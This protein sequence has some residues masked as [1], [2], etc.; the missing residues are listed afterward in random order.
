MERLFTRREPYIGRTAADI[1]AVFFDHELILSLGGESD[2]GSAEE[3]GEGRRQHRPPHPGA[4]GQGGYFGLQ[5][6]M[7]A[8]VSQ[9]DAR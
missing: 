3:G 6:Y 5:E 7:T 1:R 9:C 2:G 4:G 8:G